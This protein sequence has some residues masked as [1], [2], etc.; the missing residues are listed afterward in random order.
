MPAGKIIAIGISSF[1]ER[2]IY[3]SKVILH[4]WLKKTKQIDASAVYRKNN[5]KY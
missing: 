1:H 3:E 4:F 5:T 2:C